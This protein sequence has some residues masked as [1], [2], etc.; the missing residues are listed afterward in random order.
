M[1]VDPAVEQGRVPP[2]VAG[3]EDRPRALV[4]LFLVGGIGLGFASAVGMAFF[5]RAQPEAPNYASLA[6]PY[7]PLV[8]MAMFLQSVLGSR[9]AAQLYF[10]P[11]EIDFLFAGPFHR[12]DLLLFHLFRKG[13]GLVLLS[14]TMS[15]T[16]F[17][18]FFPRWLSFF[19]GLT[20]SLAFL[21]LAS[22]AVTLARLI[23]A[24][25]AHTRARKMVL[26]A[27]DHAG[28]GGDAAGDRTNAR[29]PFRR[30]GRELPH[31]LAGPGAAGAFRGLQQRDA[32]R[33]VVPRP[34]R[35]GGRRRLRSTWPSCSWSCG[36]TPT[37]S[38]GPTRSAGR[39]TSESS[40]PSDPAG[41]WPIRLDIAA[42]SAS[43]TSPGWAGSVP[44]RGGSWC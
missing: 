25:K 8:L 5:I 26:I 31:D 17:A 44:T 32:G 38:S 6:A 20:L 1:D 7:V 43:R 33:A 37:I 3:R 30:P 4:L 27:G 9:G 10:S 28:G 40:G 15:L 34:G 12:R 11:A 18:F 13:M 24:E 19:V 42:D 21:N 29:L 23:V 14:L 35:L 36:S 22:L 2:A 16:P 39:S 41:S